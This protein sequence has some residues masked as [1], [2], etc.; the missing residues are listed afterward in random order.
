MSDDEK[1]P[2]LDEWQPAEPPA[3]F[4]DKVM[5]ARDASAQKSQPRRLRAAIGAGLLL[6]SAAAWLFAV[7]GGDGVGQAAP[8]QRAS[9]QL[10]RRGIAVAEAGARLDWQVKSGEARIHQTAGNVFYR[11]EKG[12]PFVVSTPAG[13]ITVQGTCFRVEVDPMLGKQQLVAAGV[14][15][16]IASTVLVSVYEGRVLLANEHGKTAL[17]AGEQGSARSGRAPDAI[18]Q[19]SDALASKNDALAQNSAP[20]P[21]GITREQLLVRDQQQRTELEKLRTRVGELEAASK[22]ADG[23]KKDERPFFDPSKDELQQMAKDCKLKWDHP[24]IVSNIDGMG[25]KNTPELGITD[26][27]RAEIIRVRTEENGRVLKELRSLYVEVTGD[28][29]GAESLAPQALENEIMSKSPEETMQQ[30][31]YKLS[32]ERAGLVAAPA[33]TAGE[34]AAERLMRLMTG[35][36]D[37]YE[38]KLGGAIGPDRAHQLR[39]DQNGWGS[40]SQAQVGC[41][42]E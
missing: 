23:K 26:Q 41:P 13:D 15:A 28:K 27:E 14:G 11:V 19:N 9:L 32:H 42:G 4:A 24:P 22:S 7:R 3:D 6:A 12:G 8:L 38:Q 40:R 33:S 29:S 21:E 35:L 39:A 1:I 30:V 16:A 31:F 25:F 36:G 5:A 18:A 17:S 2:G 10:G 20:P 34:P 37:D